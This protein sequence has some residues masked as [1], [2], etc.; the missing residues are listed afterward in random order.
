[1]KYCVGIDLGS[2]TTKAVVLDEDGRV[3]G[4]GITNSRSNYD[5]ACDV[6]L[7]EALIDARF[8][9]VARELERA[10]RRPERAAG[11]CWRALE[12]RLPRAAVPG[13]ARRAASTALRGRPPVDGAERERLAQ[14][15][16]T[17][18]RAACARRRREL[19]AE[20]ATRKSD[21]FRDLAG[22]RYLQLRRGAGAR[23]G[24]LA[25]DALVGALR[26]GDPRGREPAAA[27][28]GRFGDHARAALRGARRR[29]RPSCA[30]AVERGAA[31]ELEQVGQRRHGLRPRA[32]CPSRRSRSA[33]RSSATASART[34]MFPDTRTV[35][36][37]GGQD[38]KAIQ[39]DEQRHRH[40]VPDERP[41]RRRLRPLPRLHRRR[42][43]PRA[44]TSSGPLA[45][46]ATRTRAHQ[47]DLHGVRRAPSCASGSR[48]ARS[49]RTSWPAC[50]A[51][52]SCA[53]CRCWRARAASTTSSPSPAAWPSNPAAVQALRELV[54]ENYGERT[55]QHLARL[56]LHRRARARRCSRGASGAEAAPPSRGGRA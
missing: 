27:S 39:V 35:L 38:T 20:G 52:S 13:A 50:T 16:R 17:H 46:Q 19:F 54:A 18:P 6:A 3:L 36:D 28:D 49:A 45:C 21:F 37:I 30:G 14:R 34:R 10:G 11:G 12:L 9:L 1:M 48:S 41:L 51:R 7:G 42:D 31:I 23:A 8:A 33:P 56:D 43:E 32:R 53:R 24:E 2:T 55:H 25:F 40:L 47:L 29:R 22:S 26:Q 44:C 15:R 4:R 5:V